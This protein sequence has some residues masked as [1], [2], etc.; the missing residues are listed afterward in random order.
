MVMGF[1]V[2]GCWVMGRRTVV[3]LGAPM[4]DGRLEFNQGGAYFRA[5]GMA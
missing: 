2:M 1:W 4:A 5:V 3:R